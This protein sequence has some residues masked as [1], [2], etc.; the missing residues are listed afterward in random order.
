MCP[1][2]FVSYVA[3]L[4]GSYKVVFRNL[5]LKFVTEGT[6]LDRKNKIPYS[7]FKKP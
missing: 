5:F 2:K 3:T 4:F 7:S 1:G 6:M